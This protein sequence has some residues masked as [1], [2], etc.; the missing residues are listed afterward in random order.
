MYTKLLRKLVKFHRSVNGHCEPS[1]G[2][3]TGHCY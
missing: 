3:G 2:G 1:N